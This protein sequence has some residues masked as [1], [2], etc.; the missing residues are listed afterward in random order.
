[1]YNVIMDMDIYMD[2]DNG[3]GHVIIPQY[4]LWTVA[5]NLKVSKVCK[6]G[7]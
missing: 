4:Y 5:W 6:V 3:R 2:M 7:A 1:M